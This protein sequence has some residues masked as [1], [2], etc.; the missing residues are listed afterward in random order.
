MRSRMTQAQPRTA[1]ARVAEAARQ[2]EE[3][4][5]G[6]QLFPAWEDRELLLDRELE[7][8]LLGGIGTLPSVVINTS[9]ISITDYNGYSITERRSFFNVIFRL[10][11]QAGAD[12]VHASQARQVRILPFSEA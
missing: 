8:W 11:S 1:S 4:P 2:M 5:E 10:D 7:L 3:L 12:C 6:W 9:V